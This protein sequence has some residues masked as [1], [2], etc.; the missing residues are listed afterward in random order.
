MIMLKYPDIS[1]INELTVFFDSTQNQWFNN[2]FTSK[3]FVLDIDEV[4]ALYLLKKGY[5]YVYIS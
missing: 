5:K 3:Q 1:K 2:L 4:T